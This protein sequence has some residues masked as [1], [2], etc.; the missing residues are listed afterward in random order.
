MKEILPEV[1]RWR[2]DGE[3]I[4]VATVVATRRSAP[5]PIG[6]SLASYQIR[7]EF[8]KPLRPALRIAILNRDVLAVHVAKLAKTFHESPCIRILVRCAVNQDADARAAC[9][10]LCVCPTWPVHRH[11]SGH[12][13]NKFSSSHSEPPRRH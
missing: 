1:E 3:K 11:N 7:S 2:R 13:C 4:V 6:A 9:R 5:R 8:R 12:S 10:L